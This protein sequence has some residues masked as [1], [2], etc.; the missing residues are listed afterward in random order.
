MSSNERTAFP[1][2]PAILG[3]DPTRERPR[4]ANPMSSNG[5]TEFPAIPAIPVILGLGKLASKTSVQES[6]LHG[7]HGDR[8]R[9][10]TELTSAQKNVT[11]QKYRIVQALRRRDD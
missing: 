9:R 7:V 11:A 4:A 10:V 6:P 1:A 3:L 8:H 2:I 5:R